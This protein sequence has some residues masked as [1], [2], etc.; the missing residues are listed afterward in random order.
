MR[1]FILPKMNQEINSGKNFSTLRQIYHSLILATWFKKRFKESIYSAY[2]NQAKIQGIDITDKQAKEK[3]YNLYLQAFKK[4]LYNYIKSE[5]ELATN[6]RIKRRYYSGGI[7]FQ[8]GVPLTQQLKT[9]TNLP[10]GNLLQGGAVEGVIQI[11]PETGEGVAGSALS[12]AQVEGI[13]NEINEDTVYKPKEISRIEAQLEEAGIGILQIALGSILNQAIQLDEGDLKL[14]QNDAYIVYAKHNVL[15]RIINRKSE[16]ARKAL[17]E[18]E[19][20]LSKIN[21]TTVN[22]RKAMEEIE[23]NIRALSLDELIMTLAPIGNQA[24]QLHQGEIELPKAKA[25]VLRVKYNLLIKIIS[26]KR[27]AVRVAYERIVTALEGDMMVA[28]SDVPLDVWAGLSLESISFNGKPRMTVYT[29]QLNEKEIQSLIG[30]GS[31]LTRLIKT[32]PGAA[33]ET[34][35]SALEKEEQGPELLTKTR[36]IKEILLRYIGEPGTLSNSNIDKWVKGTLNKRYDGDTLRLVHAVLLEEWGKLDRPVVSLEVAEKCLG[37]LAEVRDSKL[38][39]AAGQPETA[40]SPAVAATKKVWQL[41]DSGLLS[42]VNKAIELTKSEQLANKVYVDGTGAFNDV[43]VSHLHSYSRQ[44][45]ASMWPTVQKTLEILQAAKEKIATLGHQNLRDEESFEKWLMDISGEDEVS[46][47]LTMIQL[48]SANAQLVSPMRSGTA[49]S[50]LSVRERATV[51][52]LQELIRETTADVLKQPDGIDLVRLAKFGTPVL[53]SVLDKYYD[54][55]THRGILVK[56]WLEKAIDS[57]GEETRATARPAAERKAG[58]ADPAWGEFE[59]REL[60]GRGISQKKR[61]L[62]KPVRIAFNIDTFADDENVNLFGGLNRIFDSIFRLLDGNPNF[63]PVAIFLGNYASDIPSSMQRLAEFLNS[64]PALGN[65]KYKVSYDGGDTLS[66][67]GQE[68]RLYSRGLAEPDELVELGI[69]VLVEATRQ[70]YLDRGN[71]SLKFN[72][73]QLQASRVKSYLESSP[74]LKVVVIA[75]EE[76]KGPVLAE[77][78][79]VNRVNTAEQLNPDSRLTVLAEPITAV[80]SLMAKVLEGAVK[81][82]NP[83]ARI[84]VIG[85]EAI[86]TDR[87]GNRLIDKRS[88]QQAGLALNK[89]IKNDPAAEASFAGRVFDTGPIS[90]A[91]AVILRLRVDGHLDVLTPEVINQAFLEASEGKF[92][93]MI[94]YKS[95][96]TVSSFEKNNPNLLVFV[97]DTVVRKVSQEDGP[98]YYTVEIRG[99]YSETGYAKQALDLMAELAL[100]AGNKATPQEQASLE[101]PEGTI[102]RTP[103]RLRLQSVPDGEPIPV[104]LN[105]ARGRIGIDTYHR[106]WNDPN[107]ILIGINGLRPKGKDITAQLIEF[108]QVFGEAPF[109]AEITPDQKHLKLTD[110]E[111][112][113]VPVD[114][115]TRTVIS[116]RGGVSRQ[117]IRTP[118]GNLFVQIEDQSI[119][120]MALHGEAVSNLTVVDNQDGTFSALG[121]LKNGTKVRLT[122]PIPKKGKKTVKLLSVGVTKQIIV[123]FSN[124]RQPKEAYTQGKTE[125][126]KDFVARL[127]KADRELARKIFVEEPYFNQRVLFLD[128]SGQLTEI[129]KLAPFIKGGAGRGLISAPSKSTLPHG[130]GGVDAT[131]VPGVSTEAIIP[132]W[133]LLQIASCASC[134]T[135]AAA[136]AAKAILEILFIVSGHA[137]TVHAFTNTQAGPFAEILKNISLSVNAAGNI[138]YSTSGASKELGRAITELLNTISV[139]ALRVGNDD[140]SLVNYDL[141]VVPREGKE[142]SSADYINSKIKSIT[143][144]PIKDGGLKG[145]LGYGEFKTSLEIVGSEFGGI[146]DPSMTVVN[147]ETGTVSF[148]IWYDNE[149]SYENQLII[150]ALLMGLQQREVESTPDIVAQNVVP[151]SGGFTGRQ[152]IARAKKA[153]ATGAI[154]GSGTIRNLEEDANRN[155]TKKVDVNAQANL[156]IKKALEQDLPLPIFNVYISED[157][158]K[159]GRVG[160]AINRQISEGFKDIPPEDMIRVTVSLEIVEDNGIDPVESEWIEEYG[161]YVAAIRRAITGLVSKSY[162]SGQLG[163]NVAAKMRVALKINGDFHEDNLKQ[164]V[165]QA[166]I[167]G[168]IFGEKNAVGAADFAGAISDLIASNAGKRSELD[169][170]YLPRFLVCFSPNELW[171]EHDMRTFS[172]QSGANTY[173]TQLAIAPIMPQVAEVSAFLNGQPLTTKAE[174]P[175]NKVPVRIMLQNAILGHR[176]GFVNLDEAAEH[177]LIHDVML[178][179]S[180]ILDLTG[181]TDEELARTAKRVHELREEGKVTGN[182]IMCVGETLADYK[183]GRSFEVTLGQVLNRLKGLTAEEVMQSIVAYEPRWAIGTGLKPANEEIQRMH[184]AIRAEVERIWG[185]EA[186]EGLRIIYGGSVNPDNAKEI[187]EQEDVDGPLVG[188]ASA[189]PV[190]FRK[191]VAI[192]EAVAEQKAKFGKQSRKMFFGANLK[193]YDLKGTPKEVVRLHSDVDRRKAEVSYGFDLANLANFISAYTKDP[194]DGIVNVDQ[195]TREEIEGNVFYVRVDYN[196]P[197]NDAKANPNDSRTWEINSFARMTSTFPT[198]QHIRDNGGIVVLMAHFEPKGQNLKGP[199]SVR[200]LLPHLEKGLGIEVPFIDNILG[201]AKQ[202]VIM[203]ARPGDVL[204]AENL[205]LDPAVAKMEKSKDKATRDEFAKRVYVGKNPTNPS[206]GVIKVNEGMGVMHRKQA[207]VD[208]EASGVPMLVG[209]SL[210]REVKSGT[211][212]IRDAKGPRLVVLGGGPKIAD[213]IPQFKNIINNTLTEGDAIAIVGGAAIPILMASN[214]DFEPGLSREMVDEKTLEATREF[215]E[216]AEEAGVRIVPTLDFVV[217]DRLPVDESEEVETQ[218]VRNIPPSMASFDIGPETIKQFGGLVIDENG[219]SRFGTII[220][221]GTAG[222]SEYAQF[223]AGTQGVFRVL[224]EAKEKGAVVV[225]AGADTGAAAENLGMADKFTFV[226]TGGGSFLELLEGKDLPGVEALRDGAGVLAYHLTPRIEEGFRRVRDKV[227]DYAAANAD[228]LASSSALDKPVKMTDTPSA[229]TPSAGSPAIAVDRAPSQFGPHSI[230]EGLRPLFERISWAREAAPEALRIKDI[231]AFPDQK[232]GMEPK[233]TIAFGM[234]LEGPEGQG[235]IVINQNASVMGGIS[236]GSEEPDTHPNIKAAIKFFNKNVRPELK[237]L[238]VARPAEITNK[239]VE[240]DE[241]FRKTAKNPKRPRFSYIG[242]EI[243]VGTSMMSTIALAEALNVPIEVTRNY[244]YNEFAISHGLAK[245]V[246]AMSIPV[247]YS[248]VWEGGKHGVAKYLHELVA[249]GIIK[250]DSRFPAR[251]KDQS[252]IDKKDKSILLAVVP[253]QETQIINFSPTWG[254]AR[255]INIKLTN[256]YKKLL[257]KRRGIK[258]RYGAESGFTTDQMRTDDGRLVTL[259]LI[260]DILDEAVANLSPHEAKYIRYALDIAASEMYIPEIDMYYIGPEAAGN[261]DGLVTNAKFTEY[262]LRLFKK[263]PRFISCEDWADEAKPEHWEDAKKIMHNM[264]QMGDDFIV[265]RADLVRKYKDV[266]NAGLHKP[267]QVSEEEAGDD[268]VATHHQLGNVVIWSHR[269]TRPAQEIY[270][271][272]GAIGTGSFGGKWTLWGP[273]RGALIAAMSQAEQLYSP[274]GPFEGVS[275]PYQGALVLDPNGPY[276]DYG[277]A[278]R[279]REEIALASSSVSDDDIRKKQEE[280][281]RARS[282]AYLG[283]QGTLENNYAWGTVQRKNRELADLEQKKRREGSSSSAVSKDLGDLTNQELAALCERLE[284]LYTVAFSNTQNDWKDAEKPTIQGILHRKYLQANAKREILWALQEKLK[285]HEKIGDKLGNAS[286]A[287]GWLANLSDEGNIQAANLVYEDLKLRN[288]QASAGSPMQPDGKKPVLSRKEEIEIAGKLFNIVYPNVSTDTQFGKEY[289]YFDSP[290]KKNKVKAALEEQWSIEFSTDQENTYFKTPVEWEDFLTFCLGQILKERTA[291]SPLE[292]ATPEFGGID[293]QDIGVSASPLSLEPVNFSTFLNG[294]PLQGLTFKIINLQEIKNLRLVLN[295]L[296]PEEKEKQKRKKSLAYSG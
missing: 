38:G 145:S 210:A 59:Q 211:A 258:T 259:E 201:S 152:S 268:T 175:A 157:D 236:S 291:G 182:L 69:D 267:N 44:E 113:V 84:G 60:A 134:T 27:K 217:S 107:F 266:E 74:D 283:E 275:I 119:T 5:K 76:D 33:A 34:A 170:Q 55:D 233:D 151:E 281:K 141:Q 206:A 225:L 174:I 187:F 68:I 178:A 293:L 250:N 49:G 99:F 204:L 197:I 271:A 277:W 176:E 136:T 142:L 241:E 185:K 7:T 65:S 101:A 1:D 17:K 83:R 42:V 147:R 272:L 230:Q 51:E 132:V 18:T 138:V 169:R 95:K 285:G 193:T 52:R 294:A 252:L 171:D 122:Y 98:S 149:M 289:I 94:D 286:M 195:L 208:G 156:A 247:N 110:R 4:G 229:E 25:E 276:K 253:P 81:E 295:A 64:N 2:I 153:G 166:G 261:D 209:K 238:N 140:G 86:R 292:G 85:L 262:K 186:A 144:R 218:V 28:Y 58:Q 222:V 179:H 135:N 87:Q 249:E 150:L 116:D 120:A 215:I 243:S 54:D 263:Y 72:N 274:G 130:L 111:E 214:P 30:K 212:A 154:M 57:L 129:G 220:N 273:G 103:E 194:L 190:K 131:V 155:R 196:M 48:D 13:V 73:E 82:Q 128:G 224:T 96:P 270:T 29:N 228:A 159:N 61:N 198:I 23:A 102:P 108:D 45:V 167:G 114:K 231:Y 47:Y 63:A 93:G 168:L 162:E 127:D 213:K 264:I 139:V 32:I 177:Y 205:R 133:D 35:G 16:A 290:G 121:K 117:S 46:V 20:I 269:G 89:I 287:V 41:G 36:E 255:D 105:N 6:K 180:E 254:E 183:S 10:Q 200:F 279:V 191:I 56:E 112:R 148:G 24:L 115:S 100:F 280:V 248:V 14:S 79:V 22:N 118:Y 9:T 237:G 189:D 244:R 203:K 256:I 288:Q 192:G 172:E 66:I 104:V 15:S 67:N 282:K 160:D 265:S 246:R 78:P 207:S 234:V 137:D 37:L 77:I 221:N 11:L 21:T 125:S 260:L 239:I 126:D 43:D 165:E 188:G 40:G 143:E 226:S 70:K 257:N 71:R 3:V 50:A 26:E 173:L 232:H 31:K 91:N 106:I 62:K 199:Q 245:E 97:P 161:E 223:R 39:S 109:T 146:F 227:S 53:S 75:P 12:L 123:P 216:F 8:S 90:G 296:P 242:S 202:N 124:I 219:N 163:A 92:R 240:L 158:I 184:A 164:I 80:T 251:F 235:E 19:G 284:D 278:Q 88:G 181:I